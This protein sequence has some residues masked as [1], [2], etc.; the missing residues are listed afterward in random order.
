[1]RFS[2]P[3]SHTPTLPPTQPS[4]HT[5]DCRI[6][7]TPI[8]WTFSLSARTIPQEYRVVF[9]PVHVNSNHWILLV[10]YPRQQTMQLYDSLNEPRPT[11]LSKFQEIF[12]HMDWKFKWKTETLKST[13]QPDGTSCGVFVCMHVVG[14]CYGVSESEWPKISDCRLMIVKTLCTG[15]LEINAVIKVSM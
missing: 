5:T 13:A 6:Q 3:H 7:L 11:Q 10:A 9:C 1:M 2:L 15:R 12:S 4:C 14:L 8:L